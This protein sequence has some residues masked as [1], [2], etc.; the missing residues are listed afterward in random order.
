[1]DYVESGRYVAPEFRI[2]NVYDGLPPDGNRGDG[3][4]VADEY[5]AEANGGPPVIEEIV[6]YRPVYVKVLDAITTAN[7]VDTMMMSTS[8]M[9]TANEPSGGRRLLNMINGSGTS[10]PSSRDNLV[11][12]IIRDEW[13]KI[14]FQLRMVIPSKY[15]FRKLDNNFFLHRLFRLITKITKNWFAELQSQ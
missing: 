5:D 9:L 10:R 7:V 3:N 13:G 6:L 11:T 15:C 4:V 12:E 2:G 8:S 1:M 14:L